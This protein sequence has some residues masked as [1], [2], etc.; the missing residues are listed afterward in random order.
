MKVWRSFH[1]SIIMQW[2][3][4]H[5]QPFIPHIT[6]AHR[7]LTSETHQKIIEEMEP[8]S[9]KG[10]IEELDLLRHNRHEKIWEVIDQVN[11]NSH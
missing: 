10:K 5:H 1:H 11:V 8:F 6:L 7:D 3:G 2:G 4:K 9:G